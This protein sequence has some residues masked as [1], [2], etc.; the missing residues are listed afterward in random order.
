MAATKTRGPEEDQDAKIDEQFE[1]L[2]NRNFSAEE[3]SAM[4]ERAIDGA[5]DDITGGGSGGEGGK[6][7][8]SGGS[9]KGKDDTSGFFNSPTDGEKKQ[10]EDSGFLVKDSNLAQQKGAARGGRLRNAAKKRGMVIAGSI[11]LSAGGAVVGF[12]FSILPFELQ[13][14]KSVFET[15]IGGVR[16]TVLQT[17]SGRLYSRAFF[18]HGEPGAQRFD[19]FRARG[20]VATLTGQNWRSNKLIDRMRDAG[21][22]FTPA[23]DGNGRFNGRLAEITGPGIEGRIDGQGGFLQAW[24]D[25]RTA[26]RQ[27]K[28]ALRNNFKEESMFWRARAAREVYRRWG[29]GTLRGNWIADGA[30]RRIDGMRDRMRNAF[31]GPE[32]NEPT[33]R[34]TGVAQENVDNGDGTTSTSERSV[35]DDFE[36][37]AADRRAE[38]ADGTGPRRRNWGQL[39]SDAFTNP[40]TASRAARNVAGRALNAFGSLGAACDIKRIITT[41]EVG[42]RVLRAKALARYATAFLSVA[43]ITLT[44]E[45]DS[46]DIA[47]FTLLIREPNP[48]TGRSFFGSGSWQWASTGRGTVNDGIRNSYQSGGGWTGRLAQ[49]NNFINETV[50]GSPRN[51]NRTCGIATNTFTTIIGTGIGLALSG[52]SFGLFTAANIAV[53]A[54]FAVAAAVAESVLVPMIIDMVAG[55]VIT[56]DEWGDEMAGA[57]V[58]GY[59]GMS[60]LQGSNF[61]MRP[62]TNG[63]RSALIEERDRQIA[64]EQQ[65]MS[66]FER[67]L[68]PSNHRSLTSVAALSVPTT[69]KSS[70]I[71]FSS[72]LKEPWSLIASPFAALTNNNQYAA[73]QG[74]DQCTDITIVDGD[75][76]TDPFCNLLYGE[77]ISTLAIEPEDNLYFMLGAGQ[78]GDTLDG[79]QFNYV[80]EEGFPANNDRGREYQEYVDRCVNQFDVLHVPDAEFA[81]EPT[82]FCY[83]SDQL[84]YS[85]GRIEQMTEEEAIAHSSKV[86]DF[87][88]LDVAYEYQETGYFAQRNREPG[89]VYAQEGGGDGEELANRTPTINQRFRVHRLDQ[90]IMDSMTEEFTSTYYQDDPSTRATRTPVEGTELP[91]NFEDTPVANGYYRMP[92]AT[93]GSYVFSTSDETSRCGSRELIAVIYTVAQRWR[94]ENPNSQVRI[95]DLNDSRGH[96]SHRTGVDVDITVLGDPDAANTAEDPTAEGSIRLAQL[97]AD[98]GIIEVIGYQ[99]DRVIRD[100]AAYAE[101][102]DLPGIVQPWAGHADHFH[103]RIQSQFAGPTVNSCTT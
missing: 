43:D 84:A 14:I 79:C 44:G 25:D 41:V 71:S 55:T 56:G 91:P 97:F 61:G 57:L 94:A 80:D 24:Q 9:G 15:E 69:F 66:I 68:S 50:G 30:Q 22:D 103:V 90:V 32:A 23:T 86:Y 74:S 60:A 64:L 18:F 53:T 78:C 36:E 75:F 2:F 70:L 33:G 39:I 73:A 8:K 34:V 17:R 67:Y 27:I 13:H 4:E 46:Q 45:V 88:D 59:V 81:S 93:D 3:Q 95:G 40:E 102:N 11:G 82:S 6:G 54:G 99:D 1:D 100:Y 16:D 47:A 62:L 76:A 19:G 48:I 52:L 42:S 7:T 85:D 21:I 10:L 29:L 96:V 51:V 63:Q 35:S 98:T 31:F 37:P 77:E 26:R 12:I 72:I 49:I 101:A 89:K 58:S 83:F 92:E 5:V 28:Q 65:D 87:D 20:M 38:V